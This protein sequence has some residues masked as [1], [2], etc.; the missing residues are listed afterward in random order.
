MIMRYEYTNEQKLLKD[1]VRNF[2]KKELGGKLSEL[3]LDFDRK[4]WKKM[5]GLGWL[6]VLISEE[7]G[8]EGMSFMDL[9]IVLYEMGYA[10]FASPYLTTAYLCPELLK[11][12][13]SPDQKK[14]LLPKIADGSLVVT[15]GLFEMDNEFGF[16]TVETRAVKKEDGFTINGAKFFVPYAEDADMILTLAKTGAAD[17][18]LT[19][20]LLSRAAAGVQIE[21]LT[22]M[23]IEKQYQVTL[24]DVK[25]VGDS[26]IGKVNQGK[27]ALEHALLKA[28]VA[29]SAEMCGGGERSMEIAVDYAKVR[30]QFGK[31]IGSFQA[32]QHH[33]A[34]MLTF[35]ET[36]K[37]IMFDSAWRISDGVSYEE[38]ASMCKAWVSKNYRDLTAI[39]HQVMGG[40]GFMEETGLCRFFEHAK[41][42]ESMFGDTDYHL[43]RIADRMGI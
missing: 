28:A 2:F 33:C 43:G 11:E 18:D 36:S 7:N 1:S 38:E 41:A 42:S 8:G 24:T 26:I 16:R 13:G 32:I 31:K 5:A 21:P 23:G 27:K 17:N 37:W 35:F 40:Y 29:K 3:S 6:G 30:E 10:S 20:L 39:S 4:L 15:N 22:A 34:N 12:F 19:V 25:V 9:A 14:S